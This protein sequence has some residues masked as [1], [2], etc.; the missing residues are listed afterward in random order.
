LSEVDLDP[1]F[2]DVDDELTSHRDLVISRTIPY[3]ARQLT[4]FCVISPYRIDYI[5]V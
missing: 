4:V 2:D 1:E 3:L 5:R